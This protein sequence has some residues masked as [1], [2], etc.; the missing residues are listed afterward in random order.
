MFF[1]PLR[2]FLRLVVDSRRFIINLAVV[3]IAA[4]A[5][6]ATGILYPASKVRNA[7]IFLAGAMFAL[8]IAVGV[9][10][11]GLILGRGRVPKVLGIVAAAG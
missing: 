4:A 11:V 1:L 10:I 5:T 9:V 8:T 6:A 3:V 2:I 7:G